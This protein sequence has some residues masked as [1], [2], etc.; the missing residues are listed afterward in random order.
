MSAAA[1]LKFGLNRA[2]LD[3]PDSRR[4]A[5]VVYGGERLSAGRKRRSNGA[6]AMNVQQRRI[7]ECVAVV[8]PDARAGAD[9]QEFPSEE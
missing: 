1:D 7:G 6:F 3:I 5:A 9:R 8:E 4:F 2:C